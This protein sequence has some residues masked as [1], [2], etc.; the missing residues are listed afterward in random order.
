[1][2]LT[3][4]G[5]SKARLEI[6]WD[7]ELPVDLW[8][9]PSQ[10]QNI[11][12]Y[13]QTILESSRILLELDQLNFFQ[14]PNA[15]E[16]EL[17]AIVK[18]KDDRNL[19]VSNILS[20]QKC[21]HIGCG[22]WGHA[23]EDGYCKH[24]GR[25]IRD[26]MYSYGFPK[27]ELKRI[28]LKLWNGSEGQLYKRKEAKEH[29]NGVYSVG[30]YQDSTH[31][32]ATVEILEEK[33][34]KRQEQKF[35]RLY[36]LLQQSEL[37][38]KQWNPPLVAFQP[39]SQRTVWIYYYTPSK[40]FRVQTMS[41]LSYIHQKDVLPLSTQDI[42]SI[43]LQL[44]DI[45]RKIH[46]LGYIWGG[47]KLNDLMFTRTK[48][49]VMIFLR[50]R[51]IAWNT[52]PN[53]NLLDSCL[54]PWEIFC[55]L[56]NSVPLGEVTEVYIIA[57]I[58]YLLKSKAPNLLSY[59]PITYHNGLPSLKLFKH[60]FLS[61][62]P[63]R[64]YIESYFESVINQA[65]FLEYQERGFQT[66]YEFRVALDSLLKGISPNFTR[67]Y[68]MD[69]GYTLDIGDE[70]EKDDAAKNQDALFASVIQ[71]RKKQWGMFALCDGISTATIGSGDMAS[72]IM[73]NTFR[74][75][76][77][78]ASEEKRLQVCQYAETDLDQAA[79]FLRTMIQE[80][81]KRICK[82]ARKLTNNYEEDALVMG[83]TITAGLIYNGVLFFAWLGDS[84]IYRFSPFGWERLNY[85][86][87]ERNVRIERGLSLEECFIEGGNALTKC[88]GAHFFEDNELEIHFG[89]THLYAQDQILICSDGIP[90]FIE[91]DSFHARYENYQMLRIAS[92]LREYENDEFLNSKAISSI[93]ISCVNKM[94][95][96]HD[97][98]SAILIR[99]IPNPSVPSE[100]IYQHLKNL[101]PGMKRLLQ[102]DSF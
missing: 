76:W 49:S 78:N 19:A 26:H 15:N 61:K 32:L 82:E 68:T 35:L 79:E 39:E 74:K 3:L 2:P 36:S 102:D 65:L 37:L 9:V 54:V 50:S 31:P 4:K 42:V 55:D 34:D 90:D 84:P 25:R 10:S 98:L 62:T 97:N 86:D 11:P 14:L 70:K 100:T 64:N 59:N 45:A 16:V 40:D 41:A 63:Q 51:D 48:E 67:S 87:N 23:R 22:L 1:M 20:I 18:G 83:S 44:C 88:V 30:Q 91:Q 53:Q 29:Q 27:L 99:N 94:G 28:S 77:N 72:K 46:S 85:E 75:W 5:K 21:P 93:L 95:S 96:G 8:M 17:L 52:N 101:S 43:G 60:D 58:L 38:G 66:L 73:V 13:R 47:L 33:Y 24:C 80:G 57:A 56:N 6:Q 81:N 7:G 12:L 71:L 89:Y 92:L 69:V